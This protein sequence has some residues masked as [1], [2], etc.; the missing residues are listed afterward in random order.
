M[1]LIS[2]DTSTASTGYAVWNDGQ[3]ML[4]DIIDL[5]K[6]KSS[7]TRLAAMILEILSI[8]EN[9]KPDAVVTELTVVTRNAQVQ[10]N[11]TMI[12]GAIYG[13]C[14]KHVI[15]YYSLRPTE[16]RKAV[17]CGKPPRK[18]EELKQWAVESVKQMFGIDVTDDVADAILIGQALLKM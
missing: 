4:Y 7:G 11:L 18:R 1:K 10:R 12:L 15:D 17:D 6:V 5:K 14:L 8:L 13:Y 9:E 2:F 3:L 16:W